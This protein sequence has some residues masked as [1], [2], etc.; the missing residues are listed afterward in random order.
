MGSS[1][2]RVF[3]R[4]FKLSAVERMLSGE[5]VSALARELGVRRK[6]LCE[7]REKYLLGGEGANVL[8]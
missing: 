3:S 2:R 6:L 4:D 8:A 7:G 5:N 1:A